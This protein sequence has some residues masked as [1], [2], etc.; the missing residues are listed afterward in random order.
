M[1]T[2]L[3]P[4]PINSS[5][6]QPQ[7]EQL[8]FNT[9]FVF[10]FLKLWVKFYSENSDLCQ[11]CEL[12]NRTVTDFYRE[13]TRKYSTRRST[14]YVHVIQ[15][16]ISHT[17]TLAMGLTSHLKNIVC[18]CYTHHRLHSRHDPDF[19]PSIS[20]QTNPQQAVVRFS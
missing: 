7:N 1:T 5:K 20:H 19:K 6:L 17:I 9:G 10:S 16:L 12:F 3:L 11:R 18:M 14:G 15:L 8:P 2:V 4:L 13:K